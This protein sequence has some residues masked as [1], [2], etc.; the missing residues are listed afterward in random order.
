MAHQI[1]LTDDEYEALAAAAAVRGQ[2]IEALVRERLAERFPAVRDSQSQTHDSLIAA[3]LAAGH[4]VSVPTRI[5]DTPEEAAERE[6]L[7]QTI[8]P[9]KLASDIV[10]EDRGPR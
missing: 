10:I 3:M 6:R 9:G 4:L 7:A 8:T 2:S 1:T 5:P